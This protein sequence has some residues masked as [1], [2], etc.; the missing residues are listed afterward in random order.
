MRSEVVAL[1][2]V[3]RRGVTSGFWPVI[4]SSAPLFSKSDFPNERFADAGYVGAEMHDYGIVD[5]F[6]SAYHGLVP[7]N[8]FHDPNYLDTLLAPG[9]KRPPTA[10]VFT[11]SELTSYRAAK[12]P[13]NE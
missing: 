2:T 10:R 13:T 7:W 8:D 9:I 12:Q 5:E 1:L 11:S 6:L 3:A 4:A